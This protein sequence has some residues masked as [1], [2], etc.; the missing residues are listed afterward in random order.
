[1]T[2]YTIS[3]NF[4]L[5]GSGSI[6]HRQAV[7]RANGPGPYAGRRSQQGRNSIASR[8]DPLV[9]PGVETI[10][11]PRQIVVVYRQFHETQIEAHGLRLGRNRA[12]HGHN[13]N[14]PRVVPLLAFE[15]G[16]QLLCGGGLDRPEGRRPFERNCQRHLLQIEALQVFVAYRRQNE[17][18][19]F[20]VIGRQ[21]RLRLIDE[22]E[23]SARR[24]RAQPVRILGQKGLAV[25]VGL[26]L[27]RAR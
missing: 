25:L 22:L 23:W 6:E 14:A 7:E 12:Q 18:L 1:M 16:Q 17:A 8:K 11:L 27:V 4:I 5:R 24:E 2:S 20:A 3:D 19:S 9:T 21:T 15:S 10:E 26:K 13:A